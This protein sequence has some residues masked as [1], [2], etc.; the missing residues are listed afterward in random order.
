MN[1]QEN[2]ISFFRFEDLRVY[3]K[4]LNYIKWL[5]ETMA[6]SLEKEK[7][8]VSR[9]LLESAQDIALNIAEGSAR[10]KAQFIY[11]LKMAKSSIRECVVYTELAS[12][13]GILDENEKEYSRTQLMELTKMI[14]SLVASLQRTVRPTRDYDDELPTERSGNYLPEEDDDMPL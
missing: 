10:S 8:K 13:Y 11:Y 12:S 3:D 7:F 5:N 4:A 1:E 6:K 2:T 14:G 9:S